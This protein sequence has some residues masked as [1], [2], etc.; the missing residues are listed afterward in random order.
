MSLDEGHDAETANASAAPPSRPWL[1]AIQVLGLLLTIFVV[2]QNGL[3]FRMANGAPHPWSASLGLP[4]FQSCGS[5]HFCAVPKV[6]ANSPGDEA[7]IEPGDAV[8]YDRA[9]DAVRSKV[10]GEKL[11]LTVRHEGRLHHIELM[12]EA[13]KPAPAPTYM[14]SA[15]IMGLVALLGGLCILRGW[16][17][18]SVLLLGL[19]LVASATPGNYPRLWQNAPQFYLPFF[20]LL[21]VLLG[22]SQPL[23]MAAGRLLRREA[24]GKD[25]AW[26]RGCLYF[27]I[28]MQTLVVAE[29]AWSVGTATSLAWLP[30]PITLQSF[31]MSLSSMLVVAVY[32]TGWPQVAPA[33]R[34]RYRFLLAAVGLMCVLPLIDPI[35]M[36]TGNDYVSLSWPVVTQLIC[37]FAGAV[38]FAYAVLRHRVVDLGFAINRTLVYGVLST[39]LLLAFGLAEKG[40]EK[41][42]PFEHKEANAL[43]SAGLALAIFLVLHHVQD[44]VEHA[45][46][47]VFFKRW[48]DNEAQLKRFV[49]EAAFVTR[50]SALQASAIAEFARF[51][52]GAG[53]ALY[54]AADMLYER[55]EGEVTGLGATLDADL[56]ALVRLRAERAALDNDLPGEAALI[57]PIV[58]RSE[59]TGFFVLEGKPAGEPYRPDEIAALSDAARKI[60]Q[61]LQ[62]L[63]IDYQAARLDE[64]EQRNSQLQLAL[65]LVRGV[66]APLGAAAP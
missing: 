37:A 8:R 64:L 5:D 44:F 15:V 41:L 35:I 46:Q 7:G 42:L 27:S 31:A 6:R 19:A 11:G 51:S 26:V 21:N 66:D 24:T 34:I 52:G 57:L 62:V 50:S 48:R 3:Y 39:V 10:A 23:F 29:M 14:T 1:R 12:A 28:G 53:A 63:H 54:Q 16:R 65:S 33:E 59:V 18:P 32:A 22:A 17:N 13:R 36:L 4:S 49:K 56:P 61:D 45:V 25:P 58:Q 9:I 2:Y 30:D 47:K 38:L 55:A 40:I 60:G 43:V 20:L